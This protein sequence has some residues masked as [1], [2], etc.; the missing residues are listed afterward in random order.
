M[1]FGFH[2]RLTCALRIVATIGASLLAGPLAS[3][4][5]YDIL[6]FDKLE[7]WAKDDHA[8][9]FQ[10][11]VNTCKDMKE[12]DWRAI[13]AYA[14]SGP[15]PRDFF[16]L[17]FR[18]VLM[19][20]GQDALFTGY[21]EPEL[22]G[23]LY[24]SERYNFPVYKMPPEARERRPWLTRR[25]LL[26]S[27]VMDGRGL[28]IA[29]VDDPVEL[30]FL[31]IQGSGRIRLPD[32]KSIRVGYRGS[33]GH[34]YRSIGQELVRRQV[35]EPHQV[36]AQV[37]KNWVRRNPVDGE[38]LLFHNPSYVF[39]REV[40]RVPADK[41]PLGAMN[42][43]ITT[44]RTVAVDP[45]FVP[46]GAPV[47]IEKDGEEPLRRLMVAQDTGSAIKGAQRAD[48]FFGTGD[49]AGRAAG[50]LRDPGRLM[51]LLPIQRAYALLPE[52]AI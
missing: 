50:K 32:G 18:P 36:S 34:N 14:K 48:V 4:M 26:E 5:K 41:G 10:T 29:Y 6:S 52:S 49:G 13:C 23:S 2:R 39:F 45:A 37:I 42:R 22:D 44:M 1:V 46:L 20:D 33:N 21:F 35:Y 3:E 17:L 24:R 43:S 19:D 7:G 9:A 25:E 27:G 30:F 12:P 40:S 15:D 38:D 28:T 11:F 8:A 31:Q 51:V 47:W 16:E